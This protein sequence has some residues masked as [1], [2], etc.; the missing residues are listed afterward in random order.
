ML[1]S[2]TNFDVSN[3]WRGPTR[4]TA[5]LLQPHEQYLR[6]GKDDAARREAYRALFKA[7]VDETTL[8]R[9]RQATNGNYALGN[10][11]FQAQIEA[12]LGRRAQRAS[13]G[14]PRQ[15]ENPRGS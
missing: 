11:R 9:I 13:A 4:D 7:H 6:L 15:S 1:L 5:Q 2:E 3:P 14:R 10:A 12:A 8:T